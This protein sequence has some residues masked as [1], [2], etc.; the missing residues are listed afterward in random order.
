M[1]WITGQQ[2]FNSVPVVNMSSLISPSF[3]YRSETIDV[4]LCFVFGRNARIA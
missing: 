3:T 1:D 2:Q 4:D